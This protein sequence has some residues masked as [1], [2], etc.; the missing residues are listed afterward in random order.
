[1]AVDTQT[2][3]ETDSG[4]RTPIVNEIIDVDNYI[5]LNAQTTDESDSNTIASFIEND[6]I[7]I[8]S[9]ESSVAR[10]P[11]RHD[12]KRKRISKSDTKLTD[13]DWL[14]SVLSSASLNMLIRYLG[15][16]AELLE[17]VQKRFRMILSIAN[18]Q[19]QEDGLFNF[20]GI[21]Q[22]LRMD[23]RAYLGSSIRRQAENYDMPWLRRVE[24]E[25]PDASEAEKKRR[26]KTIFSAIAGAYLDKGEDKCGIVVLVLYDDFSKNFITRLINDEGINK[27]NVTSDLLSKRFREAT[28]V[29]GEFTLAPEDSSVA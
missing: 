7:N 28:I 29:N 25:N 8:D 27:Q 24:E 13:G 22:E 18:T 21:P 26:Y 16:E 14:R 17:V 10:I 15:D 11:A 12:K 6:V 3:T 5:Y 23:M 9:R 4:T 20:K 19:G 1:M 2:T